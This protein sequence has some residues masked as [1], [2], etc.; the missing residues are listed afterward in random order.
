MTVDIWN[1]NTS[2]ILKDSLLMS[3]CQAG[4]FGSRAV[5]PGGSV[6]QAAFTFLCGGAD[7]QFFDAHPQLFYGKWLVCMSCEWETFIRQKPLETILRREMMIPMCRISCKPLK[8]LP[9]GY[10]I[11]PYTP[12]LFA[13]HPFDHGR[14]YRDFEEYSKFGAGAVVLYK[15]EAVASASSFISY[16]NEVELDISTAPEH[17][18]KGLAD[19]CA[20]EMM[21]LCAQRGLTVHWDAQNLP[22]AE[23]AKSHGFKS[24]SD[25]AVYI[26]KEKPE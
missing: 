18:R 11:S 22:S 25:Y 7:G 24:D 21:R 1:K 20:A 26:L 16:K 12:E 23:M 6:E 9:E 10:T 14:N 5:Y 17:R 8:P 4:A 3:A 15:G 13:K 19:H 2:G